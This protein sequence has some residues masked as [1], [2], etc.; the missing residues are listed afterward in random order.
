MPTSAVPRSAPG[1][2]FADVSW[3]VAP[4]NDK[5]GS[6]RAHFSYTLQPAT[7]ITDAIAVVN[8][9]AGVLTFK[10]YASDAFT[11]STGA[12]DLLPASR[13]PVDV[14]SWITVKNSTITLKPQESAVVPF[15]LTIPANATP[16]DHSGGVVTSLVTSGGAS[17]VKLDRRLG[18]RIYLRVPGTVTPRLKVR[19]VHATYRGTID[20]ASSGSSTVTYTVANTGNVRLQAHQTIHLS[21]PLG[22]GDH[23]ANVADLPEILPGS[24]LTRTVTVRGVWPTT[25]LTATVQLQPVAAAAD[26]PISVQQVTGAGSTWGWPWGQLILLLIVVAAVLGYLWRRRRRGKQQVAAAI[27]AA[28][29]KALRTAEPSAAEPSAAEPSGADQ[30]AAPTSATKL[31]GSSAPPMAGDP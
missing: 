28:V 21:G 11:T 5:L 1:T 4:A 12:I 10:V 27:S 26:P 29:T 17:S 23:S 13:K 24:A 2:T 30:I 18:S 25:R 9:S 19:D 14:G 22:I 6:N 20:P 3:G 8:R 7:S 15:T 31:S 16:G